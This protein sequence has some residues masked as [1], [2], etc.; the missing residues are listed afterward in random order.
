MS[1]CGCSN[2]KSGCFDVSA[3]RIGE[4]LRIDT[5][6]L[7]KKLSISA[8]RIGGCIEALAERIGGCLVITAGLVCSVETTNPYLRTDKSVIWLTPDMLSSDKFNIISNVDWK[9]D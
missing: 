6:N 4:D 7:C 5:E 1:N 2:N 3:M 8:S 9:I